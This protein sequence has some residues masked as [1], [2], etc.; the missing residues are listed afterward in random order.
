VRHQ[1]E[2]AQ[3]CRIKTGKNEIVSTARFRYA[4]GVL[5]RKTWQPEMVMTLAGGIL[6]AFFAGNLAVELL[7]HAHVAGFK[8]L[9]D[10][11]SVL[12]ATLSFH[13]AALVAA[14]L[15]FKFHNIGWREVAGLNTTRWPRQVLLV[16]VALAV[17]LPVMLALKVFSVLILEKFG[18][19]VENQRAVDLILN[20]KSTGLKI[21]LA[22]F[23]VI[24]AP[25]AEEFVFRGLI[26]SGLKKL[27]WSKGAWLVTSLLFAAIHTSAPI[28]LPLFAFA[29][30]LTWLY[31]KTDGLLAPVM[32]H[33]AFNAANMALLFLAEKMGAVV[34]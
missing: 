32:A 34:R 5:W 7:R 2:L 24:L 28:F 29:L 17:S 4:G 26:F 3:L 21:Y 9:D 14:F 19:A 1:T 23:A 30:A 12:L 13:G 20:C 22:F 16:T 8:T 18:W 15:F 31:K 11:G 25:I 6:L 27:G 10:T 33:C